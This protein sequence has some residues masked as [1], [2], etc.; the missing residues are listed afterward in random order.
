MNMTAELMEEVLENGYVEIEST[1]SADGYVMMTATFLTMDF[2]DN[3]AEKRIV[4]GVAVLYFFNGKERQSFLS[5]ADSISGDVLYAATCASSYP[6]TDAKHYVIMDMMNMAEGCESIVLRQAMVDSI[7]ELLGFTSSPLFFVF[8]PEAMMQ[9]DDI[10]WNHSIERFVDDGFEIN[11]GA[12]N[13][14]ICLGKYIS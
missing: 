9:R 10:E 4:Y 11:V 5:A 12:D 2:D 1:L 7:L 14:Q 13:E 3:G 8:M 6:N